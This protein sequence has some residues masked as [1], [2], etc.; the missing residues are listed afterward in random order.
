[1]E[2][3]PSHPISRARVRGFLVVSLVLTVVQLCLLVPAWLDWRAGA[4]DGYRN[5]HLRQLMGA[6]TGLAGALALPIPLVQMRL[7][8]A[9]RGPRVALWSLWSALMV[10]IVY[11]IWRGR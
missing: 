1:M 4:P 3:S 10:V 2:Q 9:P 5:E 7:A 6:V 8:Q 11:G